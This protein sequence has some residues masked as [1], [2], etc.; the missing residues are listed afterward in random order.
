[1]RYAAHYG[2]ERIQLAEYWDVYD[3][4]RVKTGKTMLRDDWHMAPDEFHISVLGV[5]R[6]K[7]GRYLITQRKLDKPWGA[8]WWE[9]PGGAVLAGEEPEHAVVR[10]VGEETG[11]DVASFHPERIFSYTRTNAE[12]QNNYFMDLF[13]FTL[14]FS[15]KDVTVQEEE[16]EGFKLATAEEIAELGAQGIFLHYDSI[17]S[18]FQNTE[19]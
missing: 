17:K 4:N 8:G 11:L 15:E 12:E 5:I 6:D 10:E 3:E 9:F 2:S 7:A 14:D 19:Q 16:V 13:A 18:I 1:M